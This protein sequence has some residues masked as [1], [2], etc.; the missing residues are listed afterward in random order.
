MT[1]IQCLGS[2]TGKNELGGSWTRERSNSSFLRDTT[3]FTFRR[4]IQERN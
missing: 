4:N 1:S 3:L 2:I